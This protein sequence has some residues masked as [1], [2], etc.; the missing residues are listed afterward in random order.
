MM[1]LY[2]YFHTKVPI[3]IFDV[4]FIINA[5]SISFTSL[6]SHAYV[7][8]F[9]AVIII[10]DIFVSKQINIH[11]YIPLTL[12]PEGLAE[13]SQIFLQDAQDAPRRSVRDKIKE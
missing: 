9:V 2:P 10:I 8:I 6:T 5:L 11:T 4:L 3:L 13:A 12:Y 7:L 1:C